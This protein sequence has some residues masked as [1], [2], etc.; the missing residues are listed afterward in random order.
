MQWGS[1]Q[2][3]N[4][5]SDGHSYQKGSTQDVGDHWFIQPLAASEEAF[6]KLCDGAPITQ[7]WG[8]VTY[9]ERGQK[10]PNKK[11][12]QINLE[13]KPTDYRLNVL[14][15]PI[16]KLQPRVIRLQISISQSNPV[17]CLHAVFY[18]SWGF[19]SEST[20]PKSWLFHCQVKYKSTSYY[21]KIW[22]KRH[23]S[24]HGDLLDIFTLCDYYLVFIKC[25]FWGWERTGRD[26]MDVLDIW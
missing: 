13:E 4:C 23:I 3:T 15:L 20:H 11:K 22:K 26:K 10:N 17:L 12:R 25:A 2:W 9:T 24:N 8:K 1:K 18:S 16:T 5:P 21:F 14:N 7:L 6:D 19:M